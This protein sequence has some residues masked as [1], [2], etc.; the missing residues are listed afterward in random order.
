[1]NLTLQHRSSSL[2]GM[3]KSKLIGIFQLSSLRES[4]GDSGSSYSHFL[5]SLGDIHSCSITFYCSTCSQHYFFNLC[6]LWLGHVLFE[7]R[8]EMA[9]N[10]PDGFGLEGAL[11]ISNMQSDL[12]AWDRRDR[13]RIVRLF[14]LAN[15][16]NF[17]IGPPL[18]Q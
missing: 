1:M 10:P 15:I 2:K 12:T 3:I 5:K 6:G 18:Q 17:G 14:D 11:I 13:Q 8:S 7:Q 16:A 4:L 9:Q